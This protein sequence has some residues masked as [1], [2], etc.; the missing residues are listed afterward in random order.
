MSSEFDGHVNFLGNASS[1]GQAR[2]L[3]EVLG[4]LEL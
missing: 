4:G 2:Y 3:T 1:S